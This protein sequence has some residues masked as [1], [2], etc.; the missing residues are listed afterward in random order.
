MTLEEDKETDATLTGIAVSA[1]NQSA[2]TAKVHN[3]F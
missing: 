2:A 1:I 3:R